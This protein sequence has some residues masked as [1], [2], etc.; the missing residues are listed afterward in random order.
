[1]QNEVTNILSINNDNFNS[2]VEQS[3]IP[4]IIDFWAQW[5]GPCRA[6]APTFE[7]VSKKFQGK[8][9]FAKFNVDQESDI[10]T[11]YGIRSIP[12]MV[13]FSGGTASETLVGSLSAEE[14]TNKLNQI[15]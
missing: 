13:I 2:E 3:N 15:S 5:C 12:T 6:F 4:V 8:I 1:M 11:K 14:L 9:K 10:P 7:E